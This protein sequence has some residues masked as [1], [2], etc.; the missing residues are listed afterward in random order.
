[1]IQIDGSYGEG[2]GQVLRS[3]L[4]LSLVTGKAFAIDNIRAGR[5][6]SGLMRQ[7]LTAVNA[8]A[9]I[10]AARVSGNHIG[11]G[12]LVFQP[13]PAASGNYHFAVGTAG[14]RIFGHAQFCGK[15]PG[16]DLLVSA[17]PTRAK[18]EIGRS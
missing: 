3:A 12:S 7:H 13:G 16:L 8:A 9:E 1:M 11:S 2:G 4:G 10:G 17:V 6:K 18:Q 14:S 5:R 15:H